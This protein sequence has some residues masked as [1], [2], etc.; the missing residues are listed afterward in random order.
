MVWGGGEPG[1]PGFSWCFGGTAALHSNSGLHGPSSTS[2]TRWSPPGRPPTARTVPSTSQQSR[3]RKVLGDHSGALS[4]G[5]TAKYLNITARLPHIFLVI[6]II[7]LMATGT[8]TV[9]NLYYH[10]QEQPES[11]FGHT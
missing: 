8:I 6:L 9:T 7:A 10:K 2:P 1:S 3:D 5:S 11:I 4:Y